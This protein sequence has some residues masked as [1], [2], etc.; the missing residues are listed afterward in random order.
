MIQVIQNILPESL[1][2][3]YRNT[4]LNLTWNISVTNNYDSRFNF[5]HKCNS[6]CEHLILFENV[7]KNII[8]KANISK[9]NISRIR[10]AIMPQTNKDNINHPHIDQEDEHISVVIYLL[11]SDGDTIFYD[12]D[13]K[14]EIKRVTPKANTAIIFSGNIPHS[15]SR[16]LENDLRIIGNYNLI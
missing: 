12:E 8:N 1:F 11:D 3:E 10:H 6:N 7:I 9:S 13:W 2:N 4:V 15:S 14:T 16:P 5:E